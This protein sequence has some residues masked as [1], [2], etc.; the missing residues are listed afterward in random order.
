MKKLVF[1]FSLL[2]S[3]VG[4]KAQAS[5]DL[6]IQGYVTQIATAS[7]VVN[8]TV[9]AYSPSDSI[10]LNGIAVT[11]PTGWYTIT[12]V[13]GSVTGPNQVFLIKT[14]NCTGEYI[15]E[16]ASNQQGT[17][18]E[19][20][21]N[22]EV[23]VSQNPICNASF[24]MNI[25][26]EG[27]TLVPNSPLNPDY[28]YSWTLSNGVTSQ[29]YDLFVPIAGFGEYAICLAI[30]GPNCVNSWCDTIALNSNDSICSPN[31]V[32]SISPVNPLRRL[33][34][35]ISIAGNNATYLWEFGDGSSSP[36][37]NA[38]HTYDIAGIYNACLTIYGSNGCINTFCQNII[39]GSINN[40][41]N[42][43]FEFNQIGNQLYL[44]SN[45]ENNNQNVTHQ[46][47]LSNVLV[48]DNANPVIPIETGN[49]II[50]VCHTVI[51]SI[52]CTNQVCSWVSIH[53]DSLI[54]PNCQAYF[55]YFNAPNNTYTIGFE[56]Q[57][58][59]DPNT[60][61]T[62]IWDFGD[63]TFGDNLGNAEHTYTQPGY[64]IVC[65]T[66]TSDNCQSNYCAYVYVGEIAN[67]LCDAGFYFYQLTAEP[68]YLVQF[69]SNSG[70]ENLNFHSWTFGDGQ[71]STESNPIMT[72]SQL[73]NLNVYHAVISLEN[74]CA[75][76]VSLDIEIYG[77]GV[78]SNCSATFG[79]QQAGAP[80]AIGFYPYNLGQ[81]GYT[82]SWTF[83]DGE[84]STD[85]NPT[86]NYASTGY[87]EVCLT[88]SFSND[89][90]TDTY[91]NYVYVT[92]PNANLY[93]YGQV[94]A[95]ANYADE[96]TV[97]LVQQDTTSGS[98]TVVAET[99]ITGGSYYFANI[100]PGTYYIRASLSETSAYYS[101]YVPT[102]FGSQY[103]W[104]LAEP[105]VLN[106]NTTSNAGYNIALIYSTNP[107]GPGT[108]GGGIDDGP[109][110]ISADAANPIANATVVVT[111][112]SNVPQ[113]W[114]KTD[115]SGNFNLGNLAYGTYRL[116]AD[117]AGMVCVPIE[118]TLSP[119]TPTVA[120]TLVMGAELTGIA[121]YTQSEINGEI[122]PNPS[123][124]I[125]QLKLNLQESKQLSF[126]LTTITGQTV[127]S[128][129]QRITTGA[130]TITIPVNELAGG[131]YLLSLRDAQSK[132]MGV[133][134][135]IIAR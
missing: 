10:N 100:S 127:W 63:G 132:L 83:G 108:V 110:K 86:H 5:N 62:A 61:Y 30:S 88:V 123:S 109:F 119:E 97:Y 115:A 47:S 14:Q 96:G 18:D 25:T 79:Y 65:L 3:L 15:L 45:Y 6:I 53:S 85:A 134:R 33:F 111:N 76:S 36:T 43:S 68:P 126:T 102:Y 113:R 74:A 73:G 12:I 37:F 22:F 2:L 29:S 28:T 98:M 56:H 60:E 135:L 19:V 59:M 95:G 66:I 72:F 75:D 89:S 8:Q 118:F 71:V 44:Y 58:L 129:N 130:Q 34:N 82:Y 105:V 26:N 106:N 39:V 124:E 131:V 81:E 103:Y 40:D 128:Q 48:S 21:R 57:S 104:E 16:D 49:Y 94:F 27:A 125:A 7:P 116:M 107:G 9:I 69:I 13:G 120:I 38:E 41:C 67:P 112:L 99:P 91:C 17:I 133:R 51:T 121:K 24:S 32:V 55:T 23:C 87:Y 11:D 101:N 54:N 70:F 93:I 20:T 92:D 52:G 64:Y 31:F 80:T 90:C 4:M 50:E 114:T 84:T 78:T 35:N 46:W 117:V 77:G 1:I 42:A 122:F